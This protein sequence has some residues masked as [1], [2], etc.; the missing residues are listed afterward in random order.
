M[1]EHPGQEIDYGDTGD[2]SDLIL[3]ATDIQPRRQKCCRLESHKLNFAFLSLTTFLAASS[4]FPYNLYASDFLG[5]AVMGGDSS[6][7]EGS[8]ERKAYEYGVSVAAG[9]LLLFFSSYM[10]VNVVQSKILAVLGIS[11]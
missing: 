5:N 9:G 3:Q 6:A 11:L 4:V 1:S 2:R 7:P 8:A 10:A